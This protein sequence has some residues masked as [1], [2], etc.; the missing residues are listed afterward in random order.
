[1]LLDLKNQN[2]PFRACRR[3]LREAPK[4]IFCIFTDTSSKVSFIWL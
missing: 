3:V 1:M 2:V 4:E